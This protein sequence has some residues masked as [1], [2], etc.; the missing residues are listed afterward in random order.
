MRSI[1]FLILA[2]L[3]ACQGGIQ[4]NRQHVD[5]HIQFLASDE[6]KGR[7]P[8][9]PEIKIAE[10]YIADKFKEYGLKEMAEYPNY[11]HSFKLINVTT[12][13]ES[14]IVINGKIANAIFMSQKPMVSQMIIIGDIPKRISV[15]DED[16]LRGVFAA[17]RQ[18]G[19]KIISISPTLFQTI[20]QY[21]GRLNKSRV[22]PGDES[23]KWA[24]IVD[25]P[26]KDGAQVKLDIQV[27]RKEFDLTNMIA[28]LPGNDPTLTDEYVIFG[29]HHDHLGVRQTNGT[30]S[31]FNGA[32]DDASGVTAVLT[33]AEVLARQGTNKRSLIFS[34]YTAE[35]GGIIGSRI[36]ANDMEKK[37]LT[38]KTVAGI[39]FELIG[40]AS[41][42]GE[43]QG[44]MTGDGYSD[45][46]DLLFEKMKA[47][48]LNF[49]VHRNPY[50]GMRLFYRSDN[51]SFARKGIPAHTIATTNMNGNKTYHQATDEYSTMNIDHMTTFLQGL[52]AAVQPLINGEV[53]PKRID[54]KTL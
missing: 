21:K 53:T 51:I 42:K 33:L 30:D 46:Y 40:G 52:V 36:L 49:F 24:V 14:S 7:S 22:V 32:D 23:D 17:I 11:R 26:V 10:Q 38:A 50:K 43:N 16:G 13:D 15:S 54:P 12:S 34:T 28:V 47:D 45:L 18:P 29:A 48:T 9:R 8:F 31:I 4:V 19:D 39:Q 5:A 6:L 1:I 3:T 27:D 41:H 44:Y 25:A 20:S 37:G 2:F 35:E